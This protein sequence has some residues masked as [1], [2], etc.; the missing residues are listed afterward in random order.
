M[1]RLT[2]VC[3]ECAARL[4][5]TTPNKAR[6]EGWVVW[7][8]GARCSFCDRKR[9]HKLAVDRIM[10]T[11]ELRYVRVICA[12]C[13]VEIGGKEITP[14]VYWPKWHWLTNEENKRRL[15]EEKRPVPLC[16]GVKMPA[17]LT[18]ADGESA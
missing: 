6:K 1:I 8:G 10:T 7:E 16:P 12:S 13:G 5:G 11:P 9:E 3:V 17:L 18:R 14:G 15:R 4:E 2:M